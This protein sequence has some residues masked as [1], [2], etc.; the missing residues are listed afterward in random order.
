MGLSLGCETTGGV[1][2]T[3]IP[4]NTTIPC[5][6]SDMFTTDADNQTQINVRIFEGERYKTKDNNMLG[7]F[8]L[9]GI[10]PAPRGVA[11]IEITYELDANGILH[12]VAKDKMNGKKNNITINNDKGRLTQEEIDRMVSEAEKFKKEDAEQQEKTQARQDLENYCYQVLDAAES[13]GLMSKLSEKDQETLEM[14]CTEA[15]QWIEQNQEL[16]KSYFLQ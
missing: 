1:M 7:E 12:V 3:L 9:S 5:K 6:K 13:N 16:E 8:T 2:T 10:A 11:Q 15:L 4:R 14:T